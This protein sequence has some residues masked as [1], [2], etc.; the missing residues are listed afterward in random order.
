[1][2][3]IML[4]FFENRYSLKE[5]DGSPVD[6]RDIVS[7]VQ[8]ARWAP[9]ACNEQPWRFF[10]ASRAEKPI[11]DVFVN[12]LN[13]GN[14]SWAGGASAMMIAAAMRERR[15]DGEVNAYAWHDLGQAVA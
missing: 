10:V 7:L 3:D 14:R 13:E 11:F 6:D 15:R 4:P 8:A 1:M 9:S 12:V 5:F 2:T